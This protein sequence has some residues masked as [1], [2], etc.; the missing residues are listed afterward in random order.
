MSLFGTLNTA[1]TGLRVASS[2]INLTSHNVANATTEGFSQRTMRVETNLPVQ[3]GAFG[4]GTGANA[5]GS[6]R[7]ADLLVNERVLR[8]A[9]DEASTSARHQ[10]LSVVEASFDEVSQNGP[11]SLMSQ[12]FDSVERLTQ[13]PSDGSLRHEMVTAGRRFATSLNKLTGDLRSSQVNVYD[14]LDQS[15]A[16]INLKLEQIAKYNAGVAG[17]VSDL[18]RGDYQ[19]KRDQLISE[20]A[21]DFGFTAEYSGD[22]LAQVSLGGHTV[23]NAG[24]ARTLTLSRDAA[25]DPKVSLSTDSATVDVTSFIGGYFGGRLDAYGDIAGF[26]TQLNAFVDTLATAFNTQHAAGFD[27]TGAPGIDFFTFTAGAEAMTLAVD[28]T[29][30]ADPSLVAAASAASAFA[31]DN[32]NLHSLVDIESSL[33]FAAGTQTATEAL[34]SVYSSVGRAVRTAEM[35][36]A[37][38]SV[39]L[40]DL[41]SLRESVSGVDLDKE[42]SDLLAWQA[43]YQAAARL[44]TATNDMLNT[45]MEAVR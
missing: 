36:N 42:A 37:T 27:Q 19:D 23:V 8:A 26:E 25:G 17:S 3:S 33:L 6:V 35:D 10:T 1:Y 16:E 22:G 21:S 14:E 5:S 29:I 28:P 40:D 2:G 32:G 34:G 38:A 18:A 9:A 44:L 15:I 20:L 11:A 12:F 41:T 4:L 39:V 24:S 13:D 7:M 43:S 31:G 45:L 30:V